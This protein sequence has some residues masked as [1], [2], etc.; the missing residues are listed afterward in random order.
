MRPFME[1]SCER[2]GRGVV[3]VVPLGHGQALIGTGLL[4]RVVEVDFFR[5]ETLGHPGAD[6]DRIP[7]GGVAG[8]R[9]SVADRPMRN[10]GDARRLVRS[11]NEK[12]HGLS[13]VDEWICKRQATSLQLRNVVGNNESLMFVKGGRAGKQRGSMAVVSHA[14]Q[15]QIEGRN[16][17]TS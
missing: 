16:R 11:S 8:R 12:P 10:L 7:F 6:P 14:Q 9:R 2:N 17:P 15:D 5:L 1:N 13:P 3:A 4:E